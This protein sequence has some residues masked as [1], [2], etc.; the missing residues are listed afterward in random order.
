MQV[1][2][3]SP[4]EAPQ[5][6]A[7]LR[8]MHETGGTFFPASWPLIEAKL[9]ELYSR[10]WP[11]LVAI[12]DRGLIV[13]SLGLERRTGAWY[14]A[15]EVLGEVWLFASAPG[16]GRLLLNEGR[17]TAKRLGLPFLAS[18]WSRQDSTRKWAWFSRLMTK[19]GEIYLE[20][21]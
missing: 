16:A 6:R 9:V 3:A 4:E 17:A 7:V 18:E 1:R 12:D 21:P 5:V 20:E 19:I 14:T 10:G 8:Q 13:G 11:P 2:R 15:A